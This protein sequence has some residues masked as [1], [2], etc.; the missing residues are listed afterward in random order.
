MISSAIAERLAVGL[1]TL[2]AADQKALLAAIEN[3][4]RVLKQLAPQPA[5]SESA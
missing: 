3:L 5:R 1:E 2:S 4:D